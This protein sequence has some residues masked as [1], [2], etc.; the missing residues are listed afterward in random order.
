[1]TGADNQQE[2]LSVALLPVGLGSFLAGFVLAGTTAQ[3]FELIVQAVS[4]LDQRSLTDSDYR[5]VLLFREQMDRGG[6]RRH[7]MERILRDYTP[8]SPADLAGEMR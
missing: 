8:S 1:V 3:D 6:E 5:Q 4:L 2:R 7:T